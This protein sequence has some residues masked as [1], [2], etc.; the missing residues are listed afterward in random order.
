MKSAYNRTGFSLLALNGMMLLGQIVGAV[1]AALGSMLHY[2]IKE[3]LAYM[4]D[5]E[6]LEQAMENA[7][8]LETLRLIGGFIQ[9][10]DL[11]VWCFVGLLAGSFAGSLLGILIMRKITARTRIA[12][13][14]LRKLTAREVIAVVF[15]AYGLWGIGAAVGNITVFFGLEV[16]SAGLSDIAGK[17]IYAY[18]LYAVLGAPIVEELAFRKT[19][20]D[21][22]GHYG[23]VVSAFVTAMLFGLMH[24]N[25]AQFLLAFNIGLLFACIYRYTGRILY[26]ILL[27]GMINLTATLPE[28]F[29]IFGVDIWFYWNYAVLVLVGVGLIVAFAMKNHPMFRLERPD[30]PDANRQT[31][32]NPGML[33]MCIGAL[34]QI[35]LVDLFNFY[36]NRMLIG[37]DRV[38]L[39]LIPIVLSAVIVIVLMCTVGR[40]QKYSDYEETEILQ[41]LI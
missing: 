34:I 14:T 33:I 6:Q 10:A 13:E 11:I 39:M 15:M 23:S 32:R 26:T 35:L 8:P 38:Y 9:N 18:Y 29:A 1:I 37:D 4:M 40:R 31:F 3:P 27:H 24:G 30:I 5:L 20:I 22:T 21:A 12:P 16:E 25:S 7:S 19:L 17:G 41:V 36:N 28:L 2:F